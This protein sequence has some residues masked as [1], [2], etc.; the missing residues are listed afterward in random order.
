MRLC[1]TVHKGH[2]TGSLIPLKPCTSNKPPSP[3]SSESLLLFVGALDILLCVFLA[4]T[5]NADSIMSAFAMF[6]AG[7]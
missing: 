4:D 3:D 7:K 5:A 6:A 1:D 2:R